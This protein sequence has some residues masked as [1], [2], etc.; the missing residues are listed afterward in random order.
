MAENKKIK[1]KVFNTTLLHDGKKYEEGKV[2][3]FDEDFVKK[4][5]AFLRGVKKGVKSE[6]L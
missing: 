2:Y 4:H 1:K 6:D 3:E 5:K